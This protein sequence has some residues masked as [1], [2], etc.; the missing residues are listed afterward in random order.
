MTELL[1]TLMFV[2]AA[3]TAA[4]MI[5]RV[6]DQPAIPLYIVAG[7]IVSSQVPQAQVLDLSQLGISFLVFI[8]GVRFSTGKLRSVASEGLAASVTSM[9]LTGGVA[10]TVATFLN[11]GF[12]ESIVFASA[13]AFSSSLVGLELIKD[14]LRKEL[15]HS[16]LIESIQLIQDLAAVLLILVVFSPEPGLAVVKGVSLLFAAFIFKQLFPFIAESFR[17]STETVMI[18]SLAVL[19]FFV[20]AS[21]FLDISM[22][23]GA[24]AAGLALSKY[25]YSLEIVDTVGS[26]KDFFTAILFVSIGS[27]AFT[28][29]SEI[30][31]LAAGI[32]AITLLVKPFTIY[33]TLKSIG[34]DS[35]VSFLTSLGLDQVSEF[36]VIIAIQ[37]FLLGKIGEPLL[38]SVIL[39]TAVTMTLSSYTNR[40]EHWM[41]SR[42]SSLFAVPE[43]TESDVGKAED[44]VILVGYDTQG[45]HLLEK[46]EEEDAEVVVIEYDSEKLESIR[47]REVKYVFGDVMHQKSWEEANYRDA[48][49]IVSTVPLRHVSDKIISLETDADKILRSPDIEQAE[50]LLQEGATFVSVP[51]ILSS[52]RLTE[53]LKGVFNNPNYREELRRKNL[54]NLRK[55]QQ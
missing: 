39:A 40:H 32:T 51:K 29:S 2:F 8:Y 6:L 27:I 10:F 4:L 52:Q 36:A 35:R 48:D 12:F 23:I 3:S 7:L 37:A 17:E 14:D 34:R 46:L 25:P 30:L 24:F 38:Q 53:H 55:Q 47:E 15:V 16:R 43:S 54:L 21:R 26:L 1:T 44:H 41:Y 28:T 20:S 50:W 19:A 11:L 45:Q 31:L 13:A 33:S 9:V 49:L 5:S 22:V 42:F 18:F